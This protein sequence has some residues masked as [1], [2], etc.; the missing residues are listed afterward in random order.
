MIRDEQTSRAD[1]VSEG[2]PA[3]VAGVSLLSLDAGG[4]VIFL[5]HARVARYLGDHGIEVTAARLVEAEG[6]AKRALESAGARAMV[7][8]PFAERS[9]P[10]A[11]SWGRMVGTML[12]LAGIDVHRERLV[13]LL[14][15]LWLEHVRRNLWSVVPDG[16][17]AALEAV[18]ARGIRVVIVSNSEG[19]LDRLF[20]DLGLLPHL[21][22]VIDSGIVGIE[23]PDPRIFD[24]ALEGVDPDRA[25]HLG[26]TFATD[27][28]GARNAGLRCALIDEVNHY[29]GRHL[30]VPRVRSVVEVCEAMLRP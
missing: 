24:L 25:L 17:F 19:M 21:D 14:N 26:D 8:A 11:A 4:V 18:R 7:D 12:A 10:G 13:E 6:K 15:G 30:D 9:A 27:V 20:A 3:L 28:V 16:L 2:T 22:R 29:A 23:K 5:D 1:A